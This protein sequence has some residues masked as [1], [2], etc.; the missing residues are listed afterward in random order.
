MR[1]VTSIHTV[2]DALNTST[3]YKQMLSEVHKLLRLYQTVPVTT[4]TSERSFSALR[5][6]FTY[7]RTMMTEK[8]LNNCM[9]LYVHKDKTDDLDVTEVAKLFV[10]VNS[11]RSK[12]FGDFPVQDV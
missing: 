6:L 4:A 1:K 9:L 7:L 11:E 3:T 10:G 2:C 12:Y 8:R 5:R